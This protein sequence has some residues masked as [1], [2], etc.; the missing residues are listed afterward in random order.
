MTTLVN[1]GGQAARGRRQEA[2]RQVQAGGGHIP[3]MRDTVV[4]SLAPTAGQTIVDGT[5]GA[6]GYSRAFLEAAPCTVIGLD[7]DPDAVI[8]AAAFK[9]EFA[10]R[11]EFVETAFSGLEAACEGRVVNSIVLDIGVSSF[12]LD[13]ADRGFSFMRDGPLDMRMA[14]QGPSAADVLAFLREEELA[15]VF[16]AYGE[17]K[18]AR[19]IARAI[20]V[21]RAAEPFTS[22]LQLAGLV[23]RVVRAGSTGKKG[24]SSGKSIHP[25]TKVFQA[26]RIYVNDELGELARVLEAAERVLPEGGKLI[27]VTFHSLED[28]IVKQF[29]HDRAGTEGGSRHGPAVEGPAPTF[30]LSPRKAIEPTEAEIEANPRARSARLRCGVRLP[31]PARG[32]ASG[33]RAPDTF[34]TLEILERRL[35]AGRAAHRTAAQTGARS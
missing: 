30:A 31:G 3:V 19:R 23:E 6:G 5:F 35:P 33:W 11:F 32:K 18:A 22:T 8:R 34:P 28:R 14:A 27:V 16:I 25:A 20:V 2:G 17:E 15:A 10:D 9:A 24:R 12:Q 29:L 7:R 26:L 1:P 21:D 4:A 13:E